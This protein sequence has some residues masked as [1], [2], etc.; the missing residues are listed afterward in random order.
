MLVG[1]FKIENGNISSQSFGWSGGFP[2]GTGVSISP[3]Q[4]IKL[5]SSA[6][7][8]TFINAGEMTVSRDYGGQFSVKFQNV[9]GVHRTIL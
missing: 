6:T 5:K 8:Y 7:G 9:G 4:G 2:V 3:T 1:G